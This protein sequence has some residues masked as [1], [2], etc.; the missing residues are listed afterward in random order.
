MKK[1][2]QI[3]LFLCLVSSLV[4]CTSESESVQVTEIAS[5]KDP[6]IE[7][8][9]N[10]QFFDIDPN[11]D[12]VIEG[13][14]G[15]VLVIPSGAFKNSK[16]ETVTEN[17]QI[18]LSEALNIEDILLANLTTT[19][20]GELLMTDGMIHLSVTSNGEQLTIDEDNPLYIEIPT[21]NKQPG[22][23]AYE[24]SRD[25]QGNI[26]WNSP[27]A[28]EN[29]LIN[30]A[31]EDL[32]FLPPGYGDAVKNNLPLRGHESAS[33][34]FLDSLYYSFS[35]EISTPVETDY[36][37]DA[38]LIEDINEAY[39]NSNVSIDNGQYQY[40]DAIAE[41][42]T[43]TTETTDA[44]I[45]FIDPASIKVIRTDA[46]KNTF[47][48][49][50]EFE[51]RIKLIH[52]TSS[53]SYLQLYI[54]NLEKDL[55]E[56]DQ[57]AA[58]L[59][60]SPNSDCAP[61][62]EYIESSFQEFADQKLTNV[63]G[64]SKYANLLKEYYQNQLAK[65]RQ[66][67]QAQRT[68]FEN[69]RRAAKQEI[70]EEITAYRKLLFKRES[71][72]MTRYG[73]TW[74]KQGWINMDK[75]VVDGVPKFNLISHDIQVINSEGL[76]RVYVYFVYPQM[77]S[78]YRLNTTNNIDFIPANNSFAILPSS[79]HLK[80]ITIGYKGKEPYYSIDKFSSTS[81]ITL[82][83]N[84]KK[85]NLEELKSLLIPLNGNGIEN[86][87]EKDLEI[88]QRLYQYNQRQE[89]NRIE[90][91]IISTIRLIALQNYCIEE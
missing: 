25:E 74:S 41:V 77:K 7:N 19:S 45:N 84:V 30:V 73:F 53:E 13:D 44:P 62:E 8:L 79:E 42:A 86:S 29:F 21:E 12:H 32:D 66:E 87:I 54:E 80:A 1:L 83:I 76:D 69:A 24:G 46:F 48:A 68:K 64:G 52:Q 56:V 63:Q 17:V 37:E 72:R 3:I 50:R 23:M 33:Q 81:D 88:Q 9:S 28:L 78:M 57:M 65:V 27:K 43:S 90:D 36:E 26:N 61:S 35:I 31:F 59:G 55:W 34:A 40:E 49:T 85:T 22:M 16:G 70:Q 2:S 67:L 6:Y 5:D 51:E 75:P 91:E 20:D 89:A 47:L 58:N 11:I 10:R 4:S 15:T 38:I 82:R 39:G 18:E 14:G 71:Y 60:Y